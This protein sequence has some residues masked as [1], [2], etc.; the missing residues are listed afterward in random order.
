MSLAAASFKT[1]SFCFFFFFFLI[2]FIQKTAVGPVA[3]YPA[4]VSRI[5]HTAPHI[6]KDTKAR[7]SSRFNIS[8][9]RE[10]QK[11]PPLKGVC[12]C[13]WVGVGGVCGCGCALALIE[14][15]YSVC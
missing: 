12:V 4:V 8:K 14:K 13:V 5:Q 15:L 10:I 3:A 1:L 6:H 11:L 7:G 2:F 9:N